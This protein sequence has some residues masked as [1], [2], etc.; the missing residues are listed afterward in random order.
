MK[1]LL[2]ICIVFL[3]SC[4]TSGQNHPSKDVESANLYLQLGTNQLQKGFTAQAL[5]TLLK[6]ET[7]DGKNANVQN[8]LGMTYFILKQNKTALD[9]FR[10]ALYLDPQFT[11]A[12]NNMVRVLIEAGNFKKAHEEGDR[13]LRDLTY[14]QKNLALTNIGLLYVRE[15][16]YKSALP[17]LQKAIRLDKTNCLTYSLYGRS[18]YELGDLRSALPVFDAALPLC[19]KAQ[20]DEAHYYAALAYYKSG[21]H[22][23]GIGLMNETLLFYPDGQFQEKAKASL[24]LMRNNRL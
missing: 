17:Y 13:V 16:N 3:V 2:G 1:S 19:K 12:R 5:G 11:E 8:F 15:K 6:A 23:R 18:L 9:H 7:L 22:N 14:G 24:E 21:D 4:V 10:R 20:V